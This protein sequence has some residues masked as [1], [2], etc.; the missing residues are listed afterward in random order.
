MDTETVDVGGAYPRLGESQIAQ[1]SQW[2]ERRRVDGGDVLFREGDENC[3]FYVI[4]EGRVAIVEGYGTD[5][6]RELSV[7]GPG[8]FLGELNLFTGEVVFVTGVVREAGEVL[9]VPAEKLRQLVIQDPAICD[10]ILHAHLVRRSI[11]IGLGTGV[12]I[13]GS[14]FDPDTRRLREFAARNR[15]PHQWLDLESRP[16]A[17]SLLEELRVAPADTPVVVLPDRRVLRNPSNAELAAAIG[18]RANRPAPTGHDL[19]V[20][21]T[22]PAGL[23][24]AVYGASEGLSTVA[25]DAVATG[26]QAGTSTRIEN[27]LGFPAGISGLELATR[28]VLQAEKFGSEITLPVEAVALE[29]R[30]GCTTIRLAGGGELMGRT[31]LIAT[32]ARYRKLDV[33]RL[34][35]FEA[36]SIFYAATEVEAQLCAG[37]PVVVVGGG[38]SAGQAALFLAR[39]AVRVR[40]LIRGDGL[41]KSMSR[42]LADRIEREPAIEVLSN[43]EVREL[44]GHEALEGVIVEDN[45]TGER[46]RLDARAMFVFIGAEPH[47]GWLDGQLA[48][49][50]SGFVLSGRDVLASGNGASPWPLGRE[51][52]F[53]ETSSPGVFVA[54]DVRSGSIKRVA[55]AVGEGSMAVRLVHQHLA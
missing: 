29:R 51:P 19:V 31:V 55:S 20:V 44:V 12:R 15:V 21:G 25:L 5:E 30:N 52:A 48:V 50:R 54:G 32:G 37:N 2:G 41:T 28:A 39:R 26:G 3:D 7:H 16:E 13:L 18:L 49:D 34:E 33:P 23:A 4:L 43:T 10:L 40:V 45:R 35:A 53:L 17:E 38:N 24:A 42:Y 47:T 6:E 1:L 46:D 9:V 27:Y 8:R 36:T 11:L 22:G 14:R